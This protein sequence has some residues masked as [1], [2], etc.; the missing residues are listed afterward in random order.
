MKRNTSRI[1]YDKY[2]KL[3]NRNIEILLKNGKRIHGIIIGYFPSDPD[4]EGSPIHHWHIIDNDSQSF[5]NS[6]DPEFQQGSLIRHCDITSI[7]F[8]E[9][10]SILSF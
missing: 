7:T 3:A 10:N 9:D 2:F 8:E 5:L 6:S 4:D 1:L